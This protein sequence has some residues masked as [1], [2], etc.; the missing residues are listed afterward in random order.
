MLQDRRNLLDRKPLSLHGTP[1][2]PLGRLVP[3]N[4]RSVW[5]EQPGTPHR[6]VFIDPLMGHYGG[7]DGG[8]RR[9]LRYETLNA[10]SRK[11]AGDILTQRI[12]AAST[13]T[14][15]TRVAL[16]F[17]DLVNQWQA[18]VLPMY[19]HSTQ[20]HRR[21]FAAKHLVPRFGEMWVTAV[22][23]QEI[24]VYVTHLTH[25]GYAPKSVDNM[26]DTLSAILRSAVDW[27]IC[28]T[29]PRRVFGCPR[30]GRFGRS[31]C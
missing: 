5:T 26:H 30:S 17:R 12:V 27:G 29:I 18:T 21:F 6:A 22:T 4:S 25:V 2:G 1:P 3:Q 13:K 9:I 14:M 19:K 15:V 20:K 28:R 8:T 11:Q 23:R 10:I 16:T 31:G 7:P 24:Q